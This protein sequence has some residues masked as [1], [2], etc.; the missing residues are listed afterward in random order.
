MFLLLDAGVEGGGGVARE[1]GDAGLEEDGAGVHAFVNEVD[2]AAG[3]GGAVGDGLLPGVEAG[4]GGEEGGV[5]VE[6]FVREGAEEGRADE[7]HEAG[8]ADEAGAGVEESAGGFPLGV[9]REFL[10]VAAAVDEGAGEAGLFGALE[11]VG[12]RVVGEDED[13]FGVEGAASDGVQDGLH[14]R[15]GS[16]AED[17]EADGAHGRRGIGR[18]RRSVNEEAFFFP[19]EVAAAGEVGFGGGLLGEEGQAAVEEG[20]VDAGDAVP[21]EVGEEGAAL[22]GGGELLEGGKVEAVLGVKE[23]LVF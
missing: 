3:L 15:A 1:D 7:A 23:V 18:G 12:V 8:E 21:R 9:L 4:V 17:A 14:V 6:Y 16:G 5:D 19:A 11:D 13:D 20:G 2:G 10:A 22:E